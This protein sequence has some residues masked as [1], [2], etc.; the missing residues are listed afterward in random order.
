MPTVIVNRQSLY[1]EVWTDPI[2]TVAG[3]YGISD[4]GLAKTCRAADIPL[5]PRG[6][7]AKLRAGR[8]RPRTP[9]P[10]VKYQPY[11]T[12]HING[13]W[14]KPPTVVD[15]L[16]G[17][18]AEISLAAT[19]PSDPQAVIHPLVKRAAVRLRRKLGWNNEKGLRSAPDEVLAISVTESSIDRAIMFADLLLSAL[20][21]VGVTASIDGAAK[22]TL[23]SV[24][25]TPLTLTISEHV[26]RTDHKITADEQRALERFRNNRRAGTFE[27][28]Q[29][30]RFDFHPTGVFTLTIGRWPSRSWKDTSLKTI[31]ARLNEIITGAFILAAETK[32]NEDAEIRRAEDSRKAKESYEQAIRQRAEEQAN[33]ADFDQ[34][35]MAWDRAIR[36]RRY[37]DEFERRAKVDNV[38]TAEMI[39]W[40]AWARSKVAWVD[41]FVAVS[42]V[43]LDAP[44]PRKPGYW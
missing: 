24:R 36:L 31:E 23:L 15:E 7:W 33:F 11:A 34:A 30:P 39:E 27:Y 13:S 29:I 22:A 1:E 18:R 10:T 40:I 44:E 19:I 17:M 5:P 37:V 38:L 6:Y 12:V 21:K 2:T 35:A 9:L 4:V 28:P 25:G 8:G 3:R 14:V 43:I 42:D 16:R 32:A 26:R 41:P 20:A